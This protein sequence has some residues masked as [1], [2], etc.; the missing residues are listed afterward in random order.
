MKFFT[1]CAALLLVL[2]QPYFTV[3]DDQATLVPIVNYLLLHKV[4]IKYPPDTSFTPVPT[5]TTL[6]CPDYLHATT[7]TVFGNK[8]TR[9]SDYPDVQVNFPYP[10]TPSFNRDGSLLMLTN[11][12]LD[13][14]TYQTIA[15]HTWW[16]DDEK[17][18]SA[19][20]PHIYYAMEHN[21]DLDGDGINDHAFVRRDVTPVLNHTATIP[22]RERLVVFSGKDYRPTDGGGYWFTM[23]HNEGNID[24]Q[25]RYVVF[26]A[27]K[28]DTNY[29]TAIVFDIQQGQV[30]AQKG[31][32]N[33][34]WV[35]D[36]GNQV[37]DWISVSPL[38][39]YILINWIKDPNNPS[40]VFRGAIDQYDL[41]LNFIRELAHQ[42][43]HG[44]IGVQANGKDMYVQFEFGTR[45]GIWGYDLESG[46]ETQL[47]PDKY[48]GGHVSCR[49]YGRPGWCYLSTTAEGYREVFA[50]KLDDS[51]TVNR[52]AQTR[53][54][55]WNSEGGV[56]A[57]G[58]KI[59]F[60]SDWH[61]TTAKDS[62]G[63]PV[64]ETFV[65]EVEQN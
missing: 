16:D 28:K 2:S 27:R 35:D 58:T 56:N 52:F 48:N 7:G 46:Q 21:Y 24:H 47:L 14:K 64:H 50:L 45:N 60:L 62:E 25:D 53:Q 30:I 33:I 65:V 5:D 54:T 32:T 3:A 10:K 34:A 51:G 23:G 29:L 19:T 43:Q 39:R 49:N 59:I 36:N 40:S 37:F 41:H 38:G 44:D 8:I 63:H 61:A 1:L 55:T 12:L 20:Q 13:A 11:R 42:G 57:D 4:A 15:D 9:L 18:W 26:S 17:K 31:M 6:A 22:D